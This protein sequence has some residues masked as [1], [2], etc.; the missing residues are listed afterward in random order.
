MKQI[1]KYVISLYVVSFMYSCSEFLDA[2]SDQSLA[3]PDNV[4]DLQALLD[5][6][7]RMTMY[8]PS[9]GE[10][11]AD[12]YYVNQSDWAARDVDA[13]NTYLWDEQ[14]Q[15]R[16][17]WVY[18]YI[19]IGISNIVLDEIDDAALGSFNESYKDELRGRAYFF[20]GFTFFQLAQ[21][22]CPHY[23]IGMADSEYGLPLKLK[24]DV[25]ERVVR[26]TVMQTYAQIIED[27]TK[28]TLLLPD[29]SSIATRPSKAAAYAALARLY[30]IIGDYE[31]SLSNAEACLKIN[32]EL[33]DYNTLNS[34]AASPI[35]VLNKEV[36]FHVVTIGMSGFHT[37][38]IA[39]ADSVLVDKYAED[40][41]RKVVFFRPDGE[42][43]FRFKGS[44]EGSI[45][46][47]FAGLATDEVYLI[48]AEA[49]ARLGYDSEA[50]E[51]LNELLVNRWSA[52]TFVPIV[53]KTG[54]DLLKSILLEREK[55]L[56]F[57]GGIRWSDLR[58]LN[59]DPQF[60]KILRRKIGDDYFELSPNDLRY[61]FLLPFDVIELSGIKQ[62]PR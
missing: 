3:L 60:A 62:N 59:K 18:S 10:I 27:L 38:S 5:Y 47:M 34:A 17:D 50:R 42:R 15:N 13:R 53:G 61:T 49:Q 1:L 33:M 16:N 8:Y 21:L 51:A 22:Y 48:K 9:A 39:Y 31:K 56:L 36:I 58:R 30:L 46:A 28:A 23:A 55:E 12:Y 24:A 35:G 45:Y 41:L 2:K 29:R 6:E 14:A 20:R 7:D 32:A 40:D 26:S 37:P 54:E 44:Y 19:R 25:N 4:R 57:R 52:N 11:A 43:K